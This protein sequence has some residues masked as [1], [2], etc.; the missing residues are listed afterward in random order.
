MSKVKAR[1]SQKLKVRGW[2]RK[3]YFK[4]AAKGCTCPMRIWEDSIL[5][6][7][8]YLHSQ[9]QVECPVLESGLIPFSP[10]HSGASAK[11]HRGLTPV[12]QVV[13]FSSSRLDQKAQDQDLVPFVTQ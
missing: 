11:D 3:V 10:H 4:G 8:F 2:E 13:W 7:G 12:R 5:L 1:D 9:G 6:L